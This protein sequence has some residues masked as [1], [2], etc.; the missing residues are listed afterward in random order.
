MQEL[1][2]HG[3]VEGAER[4]A[5]PK[6]AELLPD[7]D[8]GLDE[9]EV[10]RRRLRYGPNALETKRPSRA[11]RFLSFFWGPIPW[12]IESAAILSAVAGHWDD[13]AIIG[14]MLFINAGVGF[15]QEFK[16]DTEIEALKATLALVARVLREGRWR[17]VPAAEL[18]PGDVVLVKLGNIVPADLTLVGDGFLSVD[19]SALTGESLPVDKGAGGTAY[20]GSIVSMG[21]MRGDVTATG[22]STRS[23]RRSGEACRRACARRRADARCRENG[24]HR[25][26]AAPRASPAVGPVACGRGG[27][28]RRCP[29]VRAHSNR[30]SENDDREDQRSNDGDAVV[31]TTQKPQ[32]DQRDAND[33]ERDEERDPHGD[34]PSAGWQYEPGGDDARRK[35]SPNS[36]HDRKLAFQLRVASVLRVHARPPKRWTPKPW[37][38]I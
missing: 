18:V 2:E 19:P 14:S 34:E 29:R 38:P 12:M 17:E 22:M 27:D 9:A 5:P 25:T 23:A 36:Q 20:S 24:R 6:A 28:H 33:R 10:A 15:W 4:T 1:V 37:S 11:R 32:Q 26:L 7:L 3:P 31:A 8:R 35:P 21:E 16:A 13:L 30:E